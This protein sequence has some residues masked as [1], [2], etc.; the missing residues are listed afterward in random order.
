MPENFSIRNNAETFEQ[1]YVRFYPKLVAWLFRHGVRRE[2]AVEI[3]QDVCLDIFNVWET[4]PNP[5]GWAYNGAR[6]R[7]IDRGRRGA[8]VE[9]KPLSRADAEGRELFREVEENHPD[10]VPGL[11]ARQLTDRY[12]ISFLWRL[13]RRSNGYK[14]V[15]RA[16]KALVR[17]HAPNDYVGQFQEARRLVFTGLQDEKRDSDDVKVLA[18]KLGMTQGAL[19][20]AFTRLQLVWYECALE[21]YLK[22]AYVAI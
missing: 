14:D 5:D 15:V 7:M 6:W 21:T 4:V 1:F 8:I 12:W 20:V 10:I 18:K 17:R 16:V 13:E 9:E 19:L 3:A 2:E 11:Y 22:G